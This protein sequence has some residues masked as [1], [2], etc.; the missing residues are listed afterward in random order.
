MKYFI[1]YITLIFFSICKSAYSQCLVNNDFSIFCGTQYGS[2]PSFDKPCL[3]NW[4]RSHGSPSLVTD[5]GNPK[6][7]SYNYIYMWSRVIDNVMQG[8][9]L[10]ASYTFFANHSYK[11]SIMVDASGPANVGGIVLYAATGLVEPATFGCG[12]P[13]PVLATKQYITQFSPVINGGWQYR[14]FSFTPTA[15]YTQLWIYPSSTSTTQY[16]ITA[17]DVNVCTDCTGTIIYNNGVLPSG[18]SKSGIIYAGSSAGAGGS[19]TV[20]ISPATS[21][22]LQGVNAVYL[23]NEFRAIVSTGVF[24]AKAIPC[25]SLLTLKPV[26]NPVPVAIINPQGSNNYL[27][28]INNL[29]GVNIDSLNWLAR[30]KKLPL[31]KGNNIAIYPT[32]TNGKIKITNSTDGL[33]NAEFIVVD[34]S[35]KEVYRYFN[36]ISDN[37]VE[38]DLHFLKSGVYFVKISIPYRVITKRIIIV[39]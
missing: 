27:N 6:I 12:D 14:S 5:P 10:F 7:P 38:L 1:I 17:M 31:L 39:R 36:K 18:N 25:S 24:T 35:G 33:K 30:I 9:G 2:C 3:A 23:K 19:G 4:S 37:G 8:E 20:T 28:T 32:P 34:Q 11:I 26:H 21:T 15:N 22:S 16:S 29:H 13:V